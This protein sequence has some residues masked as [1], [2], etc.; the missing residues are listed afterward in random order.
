MTEVAEHYDRHLGPV[1]SWMAGDFEAAVAAAREELRAVGV[2]AWPGSVV[3]DLGCGPGAHAVALG[4]DGGTVWAVDSCDLPLDELRQRAGG[5]DIRPV[6]GDIREFRR[7]GPEGAAAVLCMGD[8]LTHLPTAE[9]V[10][11]L[12]RDAAGVLEPGG[13]F[14]ATF[15][16]YSGGAPAGPARFIPVRS[17]R[18]RILTCCIEYQPETVEVTDLIH[19]WR[20]T[21][22]EFR[23]SSYRKV[24]LAPL[25]VAGRLEAEGLAVRI[26]AGARGM[27]RVVG[28]RAESGDSP[29]STPS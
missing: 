10:D 16:D 11:S 28:R 15:R 5:A 24:R 9:A 22:W 20:D 23:A 6:Q 7:Y 13:L 26:E 25:A 2:P 12:L 19:E 29:D 18:D 3:I 17:D 4:R 14:V 27:V 21:R 8:T 1:Y